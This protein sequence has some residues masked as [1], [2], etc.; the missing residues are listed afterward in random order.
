MSVYVV[1]IYVQNLYWKGLPFAICQLLFFARSSMD[2]VSSCFGC[3]VARQQPV[4]D[5]PWQ[6]AA[7]HVTVQ[8]QFGRAWG[9]GFLRETVMAVRWRG[10]V[11]DLIFKSMLRSII[12]ETIPAECG[13]YPREAGLS[14]FWHYWFSHV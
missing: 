10:L 3:C 11:Q 13:S 14:L 12:E 4:G 1:A 7:R 8:H 2:A 5:N 9:G 6:I